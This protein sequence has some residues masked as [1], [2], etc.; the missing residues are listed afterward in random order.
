M[1]IMK[2]K[3][4]LPMKYILT[5][6]LAATVAGCHEDAKKTT[7]PDDNGQGEETQEEV[8]ET[9]SPQIESFDDDIV[10]TDALGRTLPTYSEAGGIKANHYVGLFYWLWHQ[11]LRNN[12][13]VESEY[14]VTLSNQIDPKRTDWQYAD[15]YW[16]KPELG[17]YKSIDKYVMEK[18]ISLFCLLGID[19]LYLDFTNTFAY[20]DELRALLDVIKDFKEKGCN[21]PKLV[22]FFN[23]GIDGP[24]KDMPYSYMEKFYNEFVKDGEYADC[25]FI[26]EGKPLIL[27]PCQH[28]TNSRL[29][30][31]FTWRRMW[32]SF[33][34]AIKDR[35]RFFDSYTDAPAGPHPA[36][37]D[38]KV[39]QMVIS[40]GLGGPIWDV[41]TYGGGSSTT[42]RVPEYNEYLIDPE[43]TGKG[44]FFAEQM[45][46]AMKIQAPVLCVT[47]WNEWKAGAWPADESLA[48]AKMK[49]RGV[50]VEVGTYYFVDEFNEEF[51]RDIEPQDNPEY[52]DNFY[53]QLAAFMR[54]YKG[55]KEPQEAS[56]PKTID[57]SSSDCSAWN[58]VK[59]VF[60]DFEGDIRTRSYA[61]SPKNVFYTNVT[62]RNDIV[63]SRVTYDDTNVYFYVRTASDIRDYDLTNWMM[64]YIDAD[65]DKSTGWEGY[66]F[67]VN[68]EVLSKTGTTLKRRTA[69]GWDT[70]CECEYSYTGSEMQIAVPR[71]SLGMDTKPS[72]Y[73]HW[74]DNIQKL[75]DIHEFFVN[76]D[77]APE[78][79]YN[80]FYDAI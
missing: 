47:G 33:D 49:F 66:D 50:P 32:A 56:G 44:L 69:E 35:W 51:N 31:S 59:P 63:E 39:E 9:Y 13:T 4:V 29:N 80:Y 5:L 60:K 40:K 61:G 2:S 1:N 77:S 16:A 36:Y 76:G 70:V 48:G 22:P 41:M 72:F 43:Y 24:N 52:S 37:K 54:R 65:K 73:F 12:N 8:V 27:A 34:T 6:L 28:N 14:N 71:S 67:C 74:V 11:D 25:W 57:V 55:M 78:R 75:D 18:H 46:Q 10:A 21:P 30:N 38:G 17:Y 42:T 15:Y 53:Y 19:F 20:T 3:I 23:A 45:E 68:M 7:E 58:D 64:L 62:G 26:Y 79:R